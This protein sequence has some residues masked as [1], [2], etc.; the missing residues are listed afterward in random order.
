MAIANGRSVALGRLRAAASLADMQK[1]LGSI[2]STLLL[3]YD[4]VGG[5]MDI[6]G[7]EISSLHMGCSKPV[8][9]AELDEEM[10]DRIENDVSMASGRFCDVLS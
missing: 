6:V 10:D 8:G 1:E 4:C 7:G 5:V 3:S 9:S 2:R